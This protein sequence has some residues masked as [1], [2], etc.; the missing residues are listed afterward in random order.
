VQGGS[1]E[2]I[3]ISSRAETDYLELIADSPMAG[4]LAKSDCPPGGSGSSSVTRTERAPLGTELLRFP[5]PRG[6]AHLIKPEEDSLNDRARSFDGRPREAPS[7]VT[8]A[9]GVC[10]SE[11]LRVAAMRPSRWGLHAHNRQPEG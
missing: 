8:P 2:V 1:A 10:R 3:M 11:A 4:F 6:P 5:S 9:G 7:A